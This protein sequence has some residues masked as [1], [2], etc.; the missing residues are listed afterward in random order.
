MGFDVIDQIPIIFF[1]RQL[2]EK[3]TYN[4]TV[5]KLFKKA[6]DS[7]RWQVFYN[8]LVEFSKPMKLITLIKMYLDEIL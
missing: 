1:I 5:H 2:L 4:V 8:I 3:W 6:Y 7:V